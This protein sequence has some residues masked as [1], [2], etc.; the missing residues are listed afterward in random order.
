MNKK[1]FS[2]IFLFLVIFG[3]FQ[4]VACDRNGFELVDYL[5]GTSIEIASIGLYMVFWA[6]TISIVL[7]VVFLILG[8]EQ[9]SKKFFFWDKVFLILSISGGVFA[10]VCAVVE[11][12]FDYIIDYLNIGV[13]YI[14]AGWIISFVLLSIGEIEQNAYEKGL[15]NKK[16][17]EKKIRQCENTNKTKEPEKSDIW[18][19]R[20]CGTTNSSN[21]FCKNCGK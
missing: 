13:I 6:I 7:S 21:K 17:F 9:N 5:E 1:I 3:F 8:I 16:L 19:C 10:F 2:K 20:K 18:I 12:S 4:P 11:F 15:L 14:L